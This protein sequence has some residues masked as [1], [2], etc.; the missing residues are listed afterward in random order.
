MRAAGCEIV[1]SL[2]VLGVALGV[3]CAGGTAPLLA[4]ELAPPTALAL[5]F[6]VAIAL[7]LGASALTGLLLY[8]TGASARRT[9]RRGIP[10]RRLA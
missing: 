7:D 2:F 1:A 4:Q 8:G 10:E 6:L 3:A 5:L 9:R